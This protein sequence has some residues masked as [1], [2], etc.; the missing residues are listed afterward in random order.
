MIHSLE[1]TNKE[2]TTKPPQQ[3]ENAMNILRFLL[4]LVPV[5]T[6]KCLSVEGTALTKLKIDGSFTSAKVNI[7]QL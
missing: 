4:I 2:T 1:K 7:R 6:G 3:L 5:Y